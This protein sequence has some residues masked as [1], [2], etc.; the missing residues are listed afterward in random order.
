MGFNM[1]HPVRV[2]LFP[3]IVLILSLA[4]PSRTKASFGLHTSENYYEVDTGAGL[5]FKIRRKDYGAHRQSP[6]DIMSMVYK[7]VEYQDQHRGSQINSGFDWLGYKTPDVEVTAQKIFD[8]IKITVKTDHLIHYYI[9]RKGYPYIYMATW[10]DKEPVTGGG[11]CRYIVRIP[12]DR[13][14]D[15]PAPSDIRNNTGPIEAHDIYGMADGT[16]HSKHYSNMRAIDW[17]YIGATGKHVGIFMVRDQQE[18]SSGGPFYRSLLN[19]CGSDQEITYIINYGEAQ[20]EPFRTGILNK[21]TLVFT[22]GQPPNLKN[23]NY[24]WLKDANLD[25]KGWIPRWKR[26]VVRGKAT[27]IPKG[28]ETVIGFANKQAQYWTKAKPDGTYQSPF[29]IPGTYT[30]TLYKQ[31][32]AVATK[33]VS[34]PAHKITKLDLV[35]DESHPSFIWRIGEWDGTPRGFRNAEKMTHMHPSD[36]R[37][38]NWSP[39]PFKIGTDSVSDFPCVQFRGTNSPAVITFNLTP[40]QVT[41]LTLRIGTTVSYISARPQVT[42]NKWKSWIPRAPSQPKTR[43]ITVGTYRGNNT[44]YTYPI[45]AKVLKVGPNTLKISPVSGS[46]DSGPWLSASFVYDAIELDGPPAAPATQ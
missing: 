8:C 12:S 10:F 33:T 31:E 44:T 18:G 23:I 40:N 43:T 9:A 36:P 19:Q 25:L 20:T 37:M 3:L 32:L 13:L 6:G 11:L 16:T 15:G 34:V 1:K 29:M 35:S 22:D 7:G 17:K 2:I 30:A 42:V 5:V 45:P 39:W 24:R 38:Q 26:G 46:S 28:F 4:M 41:N 21:Y 27:G 14:P